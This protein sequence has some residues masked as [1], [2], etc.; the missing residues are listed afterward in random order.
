MAG[1]SIVFDDGVKE[2]EI[3]GDPSRILRFN[4]A[5]VGIVDRYYA[6]VQKMEQELKSV[7]DITID[8]AGNPLE[9]I[10]EAAVTIRRVNE[11]LR[12]NFDEVFYKGA[13]DIVFGNQN[14]LALAGGKTIYEN[15]M[16]AFKD[17]IAPQIEAEKKKSEKAI[18]KYRKASDKFIAKAA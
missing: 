15:F 8:P 13:S 7:E 2:Y 6:C 16:N 17:V 18:N 14:P 12:R 1:N 4:P 11:V 3:N 9:E 10:G 5:D